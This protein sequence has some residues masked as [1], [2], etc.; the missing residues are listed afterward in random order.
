MKDEFLIRREEEKDYREVE[1]LTREAFWNVYRPGACEH[2]VL[3]CF[4]SDPAFIKELD[5][6]AEIDGKIIGQVICVR[7]EI[8]CAGGKSVPIITLGPIGIAPEYKRKGYGKRLLDHAIGQASAL[9]YG[10][11]VIEG[12]IDFYGKSGFTVAK[13]KGIRYADDPEADYLLVRELKE[14][15]LDGVSGTFSD[16]QGYF[17]PFTHE[18]EFEEYELTFPK[19]EK[20]VLNGQLF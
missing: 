6:V 13:E 18:K 12:N 17:V 16:P 14:G 11:I 4:R 9:G 20:K 1:N 19:K 3:H 15:Y 5:F 2:Y 10:A 8:V 7:A